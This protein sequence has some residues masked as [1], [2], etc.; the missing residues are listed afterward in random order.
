MT[1]ETGEKLPR[2]RVF[3]DISLGGLPSGRI[4][5]ELYNDTVPKTAENFRALCSG[6]M[7]P[8]ATTGKPLTYKVCTSWEQLKYSNLQPVYFDFTNIIFQGMIFH[9]V[10]KDFMIQGGDFTKAN[11]TGGESIYGGT[12]DGKY[13]FYL[14][15][16]LFFYLF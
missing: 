4:I 5:F 3:M 6:D 7:G 12:F 11:G 1:V 8:G 13:V 14:F 2:E 16:Y 15:I 9:R 10:V